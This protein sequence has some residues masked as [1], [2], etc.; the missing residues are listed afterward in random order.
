MSAPRRVVSA[1]EVHTPEFGIGLTSWAPIV[2][3]RT[4]SEAATQ[5]RS[6][7][8]RFREAAAGGEGG[9]AAVPAASRRQR[10][11]VR[12]PLPSPERQDDA[13]REYSQ[14]DWPGGIQQRFRRLRPLVEEQFL[15]G[16][17]PQVCRSA[18]LCRRCRGLLSS[19]GPAQQVALAGC[20]QQRR[21]CCGECSM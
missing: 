2:L 21:S 15:S 19:S 16:Y 7:L 20:Q 3:H 12:L 10:L 14:A 11:T 9:E 8:R 18:G 13:V 4:C 6:A 1:A 5:A 17:D